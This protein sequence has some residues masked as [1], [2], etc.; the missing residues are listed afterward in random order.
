MPSARMSWYCKDGK[1][2]DY[3][4]EDVRTFYDSFKRGARFSGKQLDSSGSSVFALLA[5]TCLHI[6]KNV[7]YFPVFFQKVF[8]EL[9]LFVFQQVNCTQAHARLLAMQ[10][11]GDI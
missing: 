5:C 10:S 4:D 9:H 8:I 11:S 1:L 6:H 7:E 2:I 3:L